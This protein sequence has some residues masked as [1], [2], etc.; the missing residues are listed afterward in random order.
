VVVGVAP[1]PEE[2]A[3]RVACLEVA[4]RF[5]QVVDQGRATLATELLTAD[6][7]LALGTER[8]VGTEQ[9]AAAMAAREA[10]VERRTMHITVP[11]SFRVL[12]PERAEAESQLQLYVLGTQGQDGPHLS[13]LSH[14]RD[15]F[16][17]GQDRRWRLSRREINVIIGSR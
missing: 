8:C 1:S 16:R 7:E 6:A 17:R 4:S 12:G 2:Q 13:A 10:D 3:V 9:I 14:V 15:S 11:T 5:Y